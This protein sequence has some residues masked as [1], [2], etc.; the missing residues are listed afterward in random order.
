MGKPGRKPKLTPIDAERIRCQ[1]G[2]GGYT[3]QQLARNHKVS[4]R[5]IQNVLKRLWCYK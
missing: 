5:V 1:Y 4:V 2:S 3:Y